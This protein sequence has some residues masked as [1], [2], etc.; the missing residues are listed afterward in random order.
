MAGIFE[1]KISI[2]LPLNLKVV[3]VDVQIKSRILGLCYT[4]VFDLGTLKS[5]FVLKEL[6]PCRKLRFSNPHIFATQCHRPL[7]FQTMNSGR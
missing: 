4:K 1:I 2:S 6:S 5:L 7:I 3:T